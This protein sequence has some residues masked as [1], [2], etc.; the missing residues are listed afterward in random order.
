MLHGARCGL[1]VAAIDDA[2]VE[3][4]GAQL[5]DEEITCCGVAGEVAAIEDLLIQPL[6][7]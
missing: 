1:R 6:L 5:V 4:V 2:G 7:D 3:R